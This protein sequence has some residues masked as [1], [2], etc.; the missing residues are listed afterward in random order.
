M[1]MPLTLDYLTLKHRTDFVWLNILYTN[2]DTV[3]LKHYESA[4]SSY[5]FH[6]LPSLLYL[7]I[8]LYLLLDFLL[9]HLLIFQ[10]HHSLSPFLPFSVLLMFHIMAQLVNCE[11]W[12]H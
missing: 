3:I 12:S 10:P 1:D 9:L 7:Y 2:G 5:S 11:L 8:I 6:I 4:I